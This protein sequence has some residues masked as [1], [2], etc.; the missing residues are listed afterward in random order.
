MNIALQTGRPALSGYYSKT[1]CIWCDGCGNYG[2]WTAVKYALVELN[3]HPW[4]VC[5]CYDV[6]CHGNGSDTIEGYRFPGAPWRPIPVAAG[7]TLAN[8]K[9]P[10]LAF[11]GGGGAFSAGHF[12]DG[13]GG[14]HPPPLS[15]SD[16]LQ[17]C[18]TYNHFATHEY[19]LDRYFDANADGHDPSNLQQAKALATQVQDR[20]ACGILYQR[21]DVPHFYNRL[22]P[23]Q[24]LETTCVEEVRRDDVS[25]NWKELV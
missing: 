21:E 3:L 14:T 2:I 18:Q 4:Q 25:E 22:I 11:G 24:G 16:M 19:V 17:A 9:G 13:G 10:G 5:L 6:G 1:K 7:A 8:K 23:R 12:V 20:I 15:F